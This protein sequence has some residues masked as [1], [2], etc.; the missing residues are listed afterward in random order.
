VTDPEIFVGI[1][2]KAKGLSWEGFLGMGLLEKSSNPSHQL[3]G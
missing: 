3:G 1:A 2:N